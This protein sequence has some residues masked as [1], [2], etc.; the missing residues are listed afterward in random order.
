[1]ASYY[2][3]KFGGHRHCGSGDLKILVHL[4]GVDSLSCIHSIPLGSVLAP[5][6]FLIYINDMNK[7]I[8]HSEM[9]YSA[10]DANLL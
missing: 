10:D 6:L 5:L 3:A 7:F 8:Q 4:N 1:M 9:H 2:L